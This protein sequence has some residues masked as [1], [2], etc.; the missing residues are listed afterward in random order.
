L[1]CEIY[2]FSSFTIPFVAYSL[3]LLPDGAE[4]PAAIEAELR[5][6]E[7]RRRHLEERLAALRR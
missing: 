4:S 6:L 7:V 1:D 2:L 5:A 3:G